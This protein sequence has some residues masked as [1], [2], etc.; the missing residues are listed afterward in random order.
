MNDLYKKLIS[1]GFSKEVVSVSRRDDLL[2]IFRKNKVVETVLTKKSGNINC[3][4]YD[5]ESRH[6]QIM[7]NGKL[8]Y[9]K[10]CEDNA[11][12]YNLINEMDW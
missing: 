11:E 5:V 12:I 2:N 4:V 1:M 8:V 10:F 7:L 9:N 6:T 3:V